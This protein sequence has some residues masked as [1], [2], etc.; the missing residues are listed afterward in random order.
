MY[1]QTLHQ[2]I[3]TSHLCLHIWHAWP[4]NQKQRAKSPTSYTGEG[5]KKW[6]W[7]RKLGESEAVCCLLDKYK[8]IGHNNHNCTN[9]CCNKYAGMFTMDEIPG[10]IEKYLCQ[11]GGGEHRWWCTRLSV[12][13]SR[14]QNVP[15]AAYSCAISTKNDNCGSIKSFGFRVI[16]CF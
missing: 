9:C 16:I 12:N 5:F 15:R 7:G 6:D 3:E 8:K 4:K 14:V 11:R 13:N 10:I 1:Q 2:E